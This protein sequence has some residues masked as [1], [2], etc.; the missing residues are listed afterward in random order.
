M[1]EHPLIT[2]TIPY[3]NHPNFLKK[4]LETWNNYTDFIK[5]NVE[6]ILVDDGST[7][8]IMKL[9]DLPEFPKNLK[10]YRILQD[11]FWNVKGAR[12]LGAYVAT[13]KWV[14]FHD[15]D[16]WMD[17]ENFE[18]LIRMKKDEKTIY[19]FQRKREGEFVKNHRET[20]M[21]T[22][23]GF[24]EDIGGHD[25]DFVGTYGGGYKF[26]YYIDRKSVG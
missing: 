4:Q 8:P 3:Y 2:L 1:S 21:I 10:I 5:E 14:L 24:I 22:R 12:N 7:I 15:F 26:Y 6:I 23:K 16:H 20:H 25:E 9:K 17:N 18:K 19:R 11:I 13:G